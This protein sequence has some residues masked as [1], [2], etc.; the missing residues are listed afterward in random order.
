MAV[1]ADVADESEVQR[2]FAAV[3]AEFGG[4]SCLVN[5]AGILAPVA[6]LATLSAERVRRSLT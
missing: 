1:Q 4:L 6:P 2:L 3:D 5:N